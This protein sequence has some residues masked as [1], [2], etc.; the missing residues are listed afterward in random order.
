MTLTAAPHTSVAIDKAAFGDLT[1][2]GE[3]W[4]TTTDHRVVGGLLASAA[5]VAG[6]VATVLTGLV[7]WRV[8]AAVRGA[9]PQTGFLNGTA[10]GGWSWVRFGAAAENGLPLFVIAPLFLA[11]A[12]LAVPGLIGS[13]RLAFPRLQAFVLWGYVS[14][15]ALYIA[16]FTVVDGPPIWG[17][18]SDLANVT[19]RANHATDLFAGALAVVGVVLFAGAVNIVATVL[20][21]RRPGL[22]LDDIAPF[23]W[24]SLLA[25]AVMV[26][27]IPVFLGGLLMTAL[28]VHVN[29]NLL[30]APGFEKVWQHTVFLYGRPDVYMGV[31]AALGV[32]A[33]IVSNRTGKPL[34]GGI[35]SKVLMALFAAISLGVWAT[36]NIAAVVQPTSTWL[37]GLIAIP[38]G[39]LV[40]VL[41]GSLAQGLKLDA[42][43]IVVVGLFVLLALGAV[44]VIVA[45]ARGIE[46]DLGGA[47][48]YGQT[49]L[50]L[51][52]APL[53]G[54]LGGLQEFAPI[55][56]GRR[57]MAPLTG[58]SGLTGL[59]GGVLVGAGIAGIA[60][61]N[62]LADKGT[63]AS[64]VAGIGAFLL[65]VAIVITMANLLGSIAARKGT[66]VESAGAALREGEA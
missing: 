20:T 58:L 63:A 30:T 44:N 4:L 28:N 43:L 1:A 12:T 62:Q 39:L 19:G 6:A 3:T 48:T 54:A 9:L 40:L 38:A 41:L 55:V 36:S 33:Q 8:D 53:L 24:A 59:G 26:L 27:S 18:N 47:W 11:L 17:G 15:V 31:L 21:Q 2:T 5:L 56:W 32:A 57:A 50:L 65:A 46:S 23:A 14:A 25:S 37:T 42:S 61:K 35:A 7:A 29:A 52:A 45:G 34:I 16:A 13:D 60:Y 64:A 66:L 10:D 22:L 49:L 51:V